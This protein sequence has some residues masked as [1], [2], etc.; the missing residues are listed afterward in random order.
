MSQFSKNI[1]TDLDNLLKYRLEVIGEDKTFYDKFTDCISIE[2]VEN[3]DKNII[4]LKHS[5]KFAN[6]SFNLKDAINLLTEN[7]LALGMS[8]E[9]LASWKIVLLI[10]CDLFTFA[11]NLIVKLD[12]DMVA[13]VKCLHELNAYGGVDKLTFKS[14]FNNASEDVL[15]RLEEAK[16]ISVTESEIR[17]QEKM[18]FKKT[19][20]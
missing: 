5:I 20:N 7:T 12:D 9:S 13:A 18:L 2:I 3:K 16:I 6:I 11:S 15:E 8:W 4:L 14:K 17:L 10:V 19:N 1:I